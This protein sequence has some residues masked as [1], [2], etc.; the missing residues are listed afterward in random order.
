MVIDT[1]GR[2][3]C[4]YDEALDLAALGQLTIQR[5]S[6]V[7]PDEQAL[8][9]ADLTPVRGPRLGPFRLRTDALAAERAWLEAHWLPGAAISPFGG[10]QPP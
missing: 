4:I 3:F 7:E 10:A 2:G 1:K 6:H 5:A 8:W 9:W